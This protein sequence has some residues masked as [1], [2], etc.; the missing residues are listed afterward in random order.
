MRFATQPSASRQWAGALE[1]SWQLPSASLSCWTL[2]CCCASGL[3]GKQCVEKLQPSTCTGARQNPGS[4]FA[5]PRHTNAT[6]CQRLWP[7]PAPAMRHRLP[8]SPKVTTACQ[9]ATAQSCSPGKHSRH[10]RHRSTH[11]VKTQQ[12]P[13]TSTKSRKPSAQNSH[14]TAGPI[15]A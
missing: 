14:A 15:N 7:A 8:I 6:C 2:A 5:A 13:K 9:I 3:G 11:V 10:Q 1:A 4:P 12:S